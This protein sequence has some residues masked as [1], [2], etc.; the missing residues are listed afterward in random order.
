MGQGRRSA[1]ALGVGP[2]GCG[3]GA[4]AQE[5]GSDAEDEDACTGPNGTQVPAEEEAEECV[6]HLVLLYMIGSLVKIYL[7]P[8]SV[9]V[10]PECVYR[11]FLGGLTPSGWSPQRL[12]LFRLDLLLMYTSPKRFILHQYST[13]HA[14]GVY[15][16][17]RVHYTVF[18]FPVL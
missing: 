9:D 5:A 14:I 1:L 18:V 12:L 10:V 6:H 15:M 13:P 8:L 7:S 4:D 17:S 11:R 2:P 16:Y 3:A